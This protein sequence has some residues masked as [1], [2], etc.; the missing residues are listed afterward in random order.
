[1]ENLTIGCRVQLKNTSYKGII[2]ELL[3]DNEVAGIL[4]DSANNEWNS[5]YIYEGVSN[6]KVIEKDTGIRPIIPL[7]YGLGFISL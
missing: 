2:N 4:L 1:M 5:K 6:L 3:D 7:T